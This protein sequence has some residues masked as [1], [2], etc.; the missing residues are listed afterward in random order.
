MAV[1]RAG[2]FAAPDSGPQFH[3]RIKRD[4]FPSPARLVQAE[5]HPVLAY[6]HYG[7]TQPLAQSLR[8]DVA[9]R[10]ATA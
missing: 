7:S 1:S 8:D 6:T 3:S 4:R 5:P 2:E 9:G 10:F